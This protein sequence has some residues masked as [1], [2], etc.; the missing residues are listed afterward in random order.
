MALSNETKRLIKLAH[1]FSKLE[2]EDSRLFEREVEEAKKNE[3]AKALKDIRT[4]RK[5]AAKELKEARKELK[6]SEKIRK[7]AD[8]IARR[9]L[10]EREALTEEELAKKAEEIIHGLLIPAIKGREN[11]ETKEEKDI[12]KLEL[13]E[14]NELIKKE[15]ELSDRIK[16]YAIAVEKIGIKLGAI[17]KVLEEAGAVAKTGGKGVGMVV[18][19]SVIVIL[20]ILVGGRLFK[21]TQ[22]TSERT[23]IPL[24]DSE[25]KLVNELF[26]GFKADVANKNWDKIIRE[27]SP[28]S[29]ANFVLDLEMF[30]DS[31]SSRCDNYACKYESL[32]FFFSSESHGI[33]D[34]WKQIEPKEKKDELY[35]Q[36]LN[37]IKKVDLAEDIAMKLKYSVGHPFQVVFTFEDGSTAGAELW[38]DISKNR[39]MF[40][41]GAG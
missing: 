20:L 9:G 3:V 7:E 2:R 36:T 41:M 28:D 26:T 38:V 33:S 30:G 37:K 27:M 24:E 13:K 15:K 18:V 16:R 21:E 32:F 4:R 34:Y 40:S 6:V 19:I 17:Y 25:K 12:E 8:D 39:A 10:M 5:D 1:E 35:L 23:Y 14:L 31:N 11:L 29:Y 22:V